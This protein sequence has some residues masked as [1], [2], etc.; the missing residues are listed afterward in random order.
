MRFVPAVAFVGLSATVA[1]LAVR[2]GA[3]PAPD[4]DL[5]KMGQSV[6]PDDSPA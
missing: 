5:I 1:L 3:Q 4:P 6:L 2:A